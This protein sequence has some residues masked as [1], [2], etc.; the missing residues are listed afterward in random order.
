[1]KACTR[2]NIN[3]VSLLCR[4]KETTGDHQSQNRPTTVHSILYVECTYIGQFWDF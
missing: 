2:H 3:P 4:D 1:M